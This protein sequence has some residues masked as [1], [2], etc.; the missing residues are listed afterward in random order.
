MFRRELRARQTGRG[1]G[2]C[3]GTEEWDQEHQIEGSK[4][5]GGAREVPSS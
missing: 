1:Q 5:V 3:Y 4:W 2:G